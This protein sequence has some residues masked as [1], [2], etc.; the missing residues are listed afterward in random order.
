MNERSSVRPQPDVL[1][2]AEEHGMLSDR[3]LSNDFA[4]ENGERI[5]EGGDTADR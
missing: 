1:D 4:V 3:H 2:F 5:D